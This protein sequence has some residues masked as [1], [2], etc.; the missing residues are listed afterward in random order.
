MHVLRR[1][2]ALLDYD[3]SQKGI[4]VIDELQE[5]PTV[6]SREEDLQQMFLNILKNAEEAIV[7]TGRNGRITLR[8]RHD[9]ASQSVLIDIADTGIDSSVRVLQVE[10]GGNT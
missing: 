1:T 8:C 4:E 10:I 2:V 6:L 3:W 7:A 9:D 5:V